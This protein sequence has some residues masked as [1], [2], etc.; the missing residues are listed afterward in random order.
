ML[1]K[2]SERYNRV[3]CRIDDTKVGSWSIYK[4]GTTRNVNSQEKPEDDE[5]Q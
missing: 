1:D 2:F 3:R 4:I 5:W